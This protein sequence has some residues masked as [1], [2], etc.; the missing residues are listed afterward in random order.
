MFLFSGQQPDVARQLANIVKELPTLPTAILFITAHW[1]TQNGFE[2][3]TGIKH[4]LLFDYGGF[5]KI[6]Y[7]YTYDCLN[8]NTTAVRIQ[9]LLSAAGFSV[10]GN[11]KR[12]Y[13]HGVFVP[14]MLMFPSAVVPIVA[15]SLDGS[16]SPE[17]HIRAGQALAPLREDGVLI[18]GSGSSFHNFEYLFA[19]GAKRAAGM[20]FSKNWNDW[21]VSMITDQSVNCIWF[22]LSEFRFVSHT[23]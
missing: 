3:T 15:M 16:L 2:V 4:P 7:E 22:F 20:A 14:A 8:S 1:I 13:D 12:G 17:M 6:A 23:F 9:S 5:P 11:N 19:S 10:T 21:L 18:V